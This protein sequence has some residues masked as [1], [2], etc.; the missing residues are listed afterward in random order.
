M[1]A[2]LK[3]ARPLLGRAWADELR[4]ELG[5][6][7]RALGPVRDADVLIERLR[8]RAAGFDTA[9]CAAVQTLIAALV[10]DRETARAEML[11]TLGSDRYTALLRRLAAAVCK[12]VQRA[13]EDP[14]DEVLHALR[15]HGKR[16]RIPASWPPPRVASR[17]AGWWRQQWRCKTCW[18]NTR[19]PA[20]PSTGSGNYWTTLAMSSTSTWSSPPG[21]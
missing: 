11:A 4:A 3:A 2:A 13:G 9:G 21:G 17:C 19:T 1:R 5:W 12:A 15:I 10:S 18:V 6:L 8:D 14:P 7:G 20:S 16:L